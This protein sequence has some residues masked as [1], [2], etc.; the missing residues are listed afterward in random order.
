[1]RSKVEG[2]I[3]GQVESKK[4]AVKQVPRGLAACRERVK[5][6][7]GWSWITKSISEARLLNTPLL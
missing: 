5:R 7:V 4:A 3:Y 2:I 1:V 6:L